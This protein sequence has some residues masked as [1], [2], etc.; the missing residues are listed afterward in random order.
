[1][2]ALDTNVLVRIFTGDNP[3]QLQIARRLMEGLSEDAP[4]F[5]CR[6]T[7]LELAW[8]LERSYRFGRHEIADVLESLMLTK[9][10]VVETA[11]DLRTA[12]AG[13]REGEA[14]LG[15]RMVVAAALRAG[16]SPVVTF[17]AARLPGMELLR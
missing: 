17:K 9:D 4:A 1:M 15:D 12:I 13:W 5:V 3:E 7:I 11:A 2:I 16:A 10:V 6:E 8:V 14:G